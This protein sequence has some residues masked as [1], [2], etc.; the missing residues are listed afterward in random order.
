MLKRILIANRGEVAVRIIRACRELGIETVAIYS[1]IDQNSL[2]VKLAN[3]AICVGPAKPVKSY[4][5]RN[6]IIEAACLTGCDS[7]HPGFGFLSEN[8]QFA[9][10]CNEIG[11]KW[12]GPSEKLISLMGDKAK[13]KETMKKVGIPVVPGSDGI[14]Q[15]EEQAIK[16]AEEIGYPVLLKAS[17]RR[18]RKRNTKCL[19]KRG[20]KK[21]I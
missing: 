5:N 6:H 7:I 14:L 1:E 15:N 3:K 10:L 4:L 8:S 19:Y 9:K 18:W 21:S 16:I 17:S 11:L 12:I 13:A 2:H 20:I